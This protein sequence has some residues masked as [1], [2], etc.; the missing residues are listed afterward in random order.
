MQQRLTPFG[1]TPVTPIKSIVN[2]AANYA[3]GTGDFVQNNNAELGKV[4]KKMHKINASV[5][6]SET[7]LKVLF[8]VQKTRSGMSYSHVCKVVFFQCTLTIGWLLLIR[9]RK[10]IRRPFKGVVTRWNSDYEEV[11]ATNIFMGDLKCS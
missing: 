5:Y 6:R 11:K 7:R 9:P 2:K 1:T 10:V 4:T 8:Q 3:S